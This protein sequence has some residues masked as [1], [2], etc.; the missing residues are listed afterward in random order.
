V[1]ATDVGAVREMVTQGQTG[2]VVPPGD[3]EALA[4]AVLMYLALPQSARRGKVQAARMKVEQE[5]ALDAIARQ[6]NQL[7]ESVRSLRPSQSREIG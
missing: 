2:F 4:R 1:V 6:Q 3:S 7:Y 5:F